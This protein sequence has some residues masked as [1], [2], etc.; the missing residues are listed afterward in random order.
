MK[1]RRSLTLRTEHLGEL[2]TAELTSVAGADVAPAHT[3]PPVR[4]VSEALRCAIYDPNSI[5]CRVVSDYV[6]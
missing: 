3:T 2:T 4:C 6:C 1:P 5:V